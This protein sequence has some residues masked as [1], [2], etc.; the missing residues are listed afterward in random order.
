MLKLWRQPLK[1]WKKNVVASDKSRE[2]G[3]TDASQEVNKRIT[4]QNF[5]HSLQSQGVPEDH[6]KTLGENL[7][8][9]N[10]QREQFAGHNRSQNEHRRAQKTWKV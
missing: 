5:S 2:T 4:N 9:R 7:V 3:N 8:P 1:K 6:S 10:F